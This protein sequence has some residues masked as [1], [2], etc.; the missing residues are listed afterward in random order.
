ML[1]FLKKNK[2]V[3]FIISYI[4]RLNYS[5]FWKYRS[6]MTKDVE[7]NIKTYLEDEILL[8]FFDDK[9]NE[10]LHIIE[11][12][13]GFGLRLFNLKK[14]KKNYSLTGF[15]I[16]QKYLD[17]ANKYNLQKQMNIEFIKRNI[18]DIKFEQDI[19]YLISSFTLIYVKK[20]SLIKFFLNNK[21]KI[22]KGFILIEYH[23]KKK[24]D[25]MS[26]YVHNFEEIFNNS[27]LNNFQIEFNKINNKRWIK[28]DHEAY[29][30][31]GHINEN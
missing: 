2:L 30:I 25:N 8:N 12:G 16:N 19:D 7:F 15:D 18:E 14:K 31:S 4:L 20:K 26:Y 24:S 11:L 10:K 5:F 1:S 17:F 22:K 28:K 21:N 27:N 23:S 9:S 13:C 3:W 6:L 29:T